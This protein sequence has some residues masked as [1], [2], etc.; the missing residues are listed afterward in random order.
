MSVT[1][2]LC[3]TLLPS[4]SVCAVRALV[5]RPY[6]Y[7]SYHLRPAPKR[8]SA[9]AV[10]APLPAP[11]HSLRQT[12]WR[13]GGM[14]DDDGDD[15]TRAW[16][17]VGIQPTTGRVWEMMKM[18]GRSAAPRRGGGGL[19][20][21]G[22]AMQPVGG[23]SGAARAGVASRRARRRTSKLGW[24]GK[25]ERREVGP[26]MRIGSYRAVRS[27]ELSRGAVDGHLEAG[28]MAE[29]GGAARFEDGWTRLEPRGGLRLALRLGCWLRAAVVVAA[30]GDDE[31]GMH[32]TPIRGWIVLAHDQRRLH[33]LGH[34]VSFRAAEV[35][36]EGVP[37]TLPPARAAGNMRLLAIF[38]ASF[39]LEW[40][41]SIAIV[42]LWLRH[43]A[44]RW[45][46]S[47]TRRRREEEGGNP[48]AR[49]WNHGAANEDGMAA[50]TSRAST[51]HS[52]AR[53]EVFLLMTLPF[54]PNSIQSSSNC[55]Q[56]LVLFE[57]GVK[58]D[59][60]LA[61]RFAKYRDGR[62]NIRL[63][64]KETC[65]L[66]YDVQ[67]TSNL[68]APLTSIWKSLEFNV[69]YL[70]HYIFSL[71]LMLSAPLSVASDYLWLQTRRA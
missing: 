52:N 19:R 66:A 32:R 42:I 69:H 7:P 45:P 5:L 37:Y 16:A 67:V 55:N 23:G 47:I 22:C 15:D 20:M 62:E 53:F 44:F 1:R 25:R 41:F 49:Q 2:C 6:L 40:S 8:R 26:G 63:S 11:S 17:E 71:Q 48:R 13:R 57:R 27:R 29:A 36:V 70:A 18:R 3:R 10:A 30:D 68:A 59:Q 51:F 12:S 61:L 14:R 39:A 60:S 33:E 9:D 54:L 35:E 46:L 50:L 58:N 34:F 21:R 65:T 43:A 31:M 28:M 64:F 24:D 38:H 56:V 4:T